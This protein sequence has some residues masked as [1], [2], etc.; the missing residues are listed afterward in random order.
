MQNGGVILINTFTK[1][2]TRKSLIMVSTII[3]IVSLMLPACVK[4]NVKEL[5]VKNINSAETSKAIDIN[6]REDI[7]NEIEINNDIEIEEKLK[8]SG[9][10]HESKE[11]VSNLGK[12]NI[13]I[14]KSSNDSGIK[15]IITD[16]NNVELYRTPEDKIYYGDCGVQIESIHIGDLNNDHLEDITIIFSSYIGAGYLGGLTFDRSYVLL[17]VNESFIFDHI[18][19]EIGNQ[20]HINTSYHDVKFYYEEHDWSYDSY[21]LDFVEHVVNNDNVSITASYPQIISE[22]IGLQNHTND[23]IDY[24]MNEIINCF[25]DMDNYVS[26]DIGSEVTRKGR[27]LSINFLVDW[28]VEK[29]AHPNLELHT[30]NIDLEVGDALILSDIISYSEEEIDEILNLCS[31]ISYAGLSEDTLSEYLKT[32]IKGEWDYANAYMSEKKIYITIPTNYASG[33]YLTLEYNLEDLEQ[34]LKYE[35]ILKRII[36]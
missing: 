28:Y 2:K 4:N 7:V 22:D 27:F 36:D 11:E 20:R 33:C 10:I 18:Q 12:L 26:I 5:V 29:T 31:R 32:E 13:Q 9:L 8:T 14:G 30:L 35:G 15:I 3:L 6:K 34:Y 19:Y 23:I 25:N 1:R 16:L 17:Q 21:D 24:Y